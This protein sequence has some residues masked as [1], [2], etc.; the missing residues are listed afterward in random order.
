MTILGQKTGHCI[1]R[2]GQKIMTGHLPKKPDC[3]VKNRTPGNLINALF[4]RLIGQL[5]ATY[6]QLFNT[7]LLF[8]ALAEGITLGARKLDSLGYNPGGC[9]SVL[10][11][12]VRGFDC[13]LGFSVVGACSKLS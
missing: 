9:L 2:F 11:C 8:N 5:G 4:R 3:P 7:L 1:V 10:L 13:G 12:K 6:M